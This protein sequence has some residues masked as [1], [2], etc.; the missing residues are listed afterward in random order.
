[1]SESEP[2][3]SG[4]PSFFQRFFVPLTVFERIDRLEAF[5]SAFPGEYCGFNPDGTLVF[6]KGFLAL[7]GLSALRGLPDIQHALRPGDGAA[8]ETCFT[9][10]EQEKQKFVLKAQILDGSKILRITGS[11]GE[12]LSGYDRYRIL[13]IEDITVQER[14]LEERR[15]AQ[16]DFEHEIRKFHAL[17]GVLRQPMWIY[18]PRGAVIWCNTAYCKLMGQP[19][20]KIIDEKLDLP[21][22]TPKKQAKGTKTLS[23]LA[24]ET[25]ASGV[26]IVE[27]KYLIVNG[28]RKLF[29]VA[30]TPLPHLDFVIGEAQD[31]SREEDLE[32][33]HERHTR[34]QHDLLE[35]LRSAIA[36]FDGSQKLE[37]YNAAFAQLWRLD[38]AWLNTRPKLGDI[39]EQLRETRRLPEQADFRRYKQGWLDLFTSLIGAHEDMLYLP[40]DTVLRLLVVPHPMGGLMMICEDVTSGLALQS[41]YNTLMAVQRET[42]D[43]L[44]EGVAVYGGDGRLKL[45]NSAYAAMWHF[46]PEDLDSGLHVTQVIDKSRGFFEGASWDETRRRML[47]E[48]FAREDRLGELRLLDGRILHYVTV[49][50]PDGGTMV[51][52]QDVTDK[53]RV[54]EALREKNMALEAAER[55]KL[56]FLANV[57]YQLRTPLNAIIG[58]NE[59]LDQEYFGPLNPRQ[60]EY[61]KGMHEA[62]ERLKNLIND[63]LDLSTIEAGYMTLS[64]SHVAV[65]GIVGDLYNLTQEWARGQKIE[66]TLDCAADVGQAFLDERR[67]KQGLLNLIR[68]AIAYTPAGGR[69]TLGAKRMGDQVIFS[70]TDTGVGIDPVDQERIFRPFEKT[71][72]PRDD[73]LGDQRGGAGLGLTL[74]RNIVTLHGGT[75]R[76]ESRKGQGSVFSLELPALSAGSELAT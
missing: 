23:G 5:L 43:N 22:T 71:D 35:Q 24:A 75:I 30:L 16:H 47:A 29:Q 58:F 28:E 40:D 45:W 36:I 74:V 65:A 33:K 64:R 11:A 21:F 46:N 31:I 17:L 13:W 12:A 37:F 53:V 25:L 50:L 63:I 49:A 61:T 42:L 9:K 26:G 67:I 3:P 8:L 56:D 57:S 20:E 69:I 51:T 76:L 68:N 2:P 7:L 48:F 60:K 62:S 15:T 73:G 66:V 27:S 59:I 6:S 41:S 10:L 39:L 55:L 38:D 54:E 4:R 44:G 32:K 14:E 34:A 70:V 72:A 18:S 1:M 52:F 19:L